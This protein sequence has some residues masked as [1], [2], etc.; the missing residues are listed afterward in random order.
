VQIKKK[1]GF[2]KIFKFK[3]FE[4]CKHID[5]NTKHKSYDEKLK[6]MRI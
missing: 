2:Y 1:K 5:M 6:N 4:L 3:I